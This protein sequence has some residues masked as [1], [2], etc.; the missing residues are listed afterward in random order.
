MAKLRLISFHILA[1]VLILLFFTGIGSREGKMYE[2]VVIYLYYGVINIAVFYIN[3]LYIL[4]TFLNSRRFLGC[5]LSI[6]GLLVISSLVKYSI[7][8][9]YPEV[10]LSYRANDGHEMLLAFWKYF[11]I[12][13]FSGMFF[14][15]IS[16]ALKFGVDWFINEKIR[17]NLENEKLS[18]ELSFLKSQINPHFLFNS[19]NNIYSLAYRHS[20]ETPQAILKLSEMM[21][22]ML[23][24]SNEPGVNLCKEIRYI[25]NYIELQRLRFPNGG[26]IKLSVTGE[27]SRA[28]IAPLILI[29]FIENAFKHGVATD[30]EHPIDIKIIIDSV[31]V[32]LQVV[33][34]RSEQNK[35][36]AS[37]IGLHNVN[38]RL[39]IL[40]KDR[41]QLDIK[42]SDKFYICN[43]IIEL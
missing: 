24:E 21:R 3:L 31:S 26:N 32:H 17:K 41:Y 25:E 20:E 18:A 33:N 8:S 43:L 15:I 13:L 12:C 19:L 38:R 34:L 2:A 40:Y 22:Y 10:I 30:P 39:E 9:F 7:A 11:I 37:G 1:W 16:T 23:Q 42:S 4:P 27:D 5:T 14:I 28:Y 35:D 36:E 29:P 6:L